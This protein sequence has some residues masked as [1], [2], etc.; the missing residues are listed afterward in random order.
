[1]DHNWF[2]NVCNYFQALTYSLFN[3]KLFLKGYRHEA[4]APSLPAR[5]SIDWNAKWGPIWVSFQS[6]DSDWPNTVLARKQIE[7][8]ANSHGHRW[9]ESFGLGTRKSILIM[10]TW[11]VTQF[12]Y[13][14]HFVLVNS[15]GC[16]WK[17]SNPRPFLDRE[18]CPCHY[19]LPTR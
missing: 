5:T 1:M 9:R 7:P 10:P 11:I 8:E 3:T 18:L 14:H 15:Y 13:Q 12:G 6:D 16:D 19:T 4:N 17:W 2:G